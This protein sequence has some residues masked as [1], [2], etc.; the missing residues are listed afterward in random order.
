[1]TPAFDETEAATLIACL[2]RHAGRGATVSYLALAGEMAL[3]PPHRI[4]RLTLALEDL[5]RADIAAGRPLLAAVAVGKTGLP[6]RGFFQLLQA[7]GRYEGADS[8]AAAAAHHAEE[9]SAARAYWARE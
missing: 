3:R 5:V 2:K 9:L 4:H 7:L 6:G 1:M 8:G